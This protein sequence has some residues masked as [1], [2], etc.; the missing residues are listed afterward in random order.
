M[1]FIRYSTRECRMADATDIPLST[2]PLRSRRA[3]AISRLAAPLRDPFAAVG[4][5]I[6]TVFLVIALLADAIAPHDPLE[7]LFTADGNLA[8][9]EP[10]GWQHPLGTTNLGRD[11][12]SQLLVGTRA[13]LIVGLTAAVAVASIG[14]V[15][16]LISGF[17]GGWTDAVLMRFT[18]IA[19]GIPFLPFVILIS[20]L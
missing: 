2:A 20:G 1:F 16:G 4:F 13:A 11:I 9:S 19:L 10:P 7:I 12:F 8:R 18:D 5:L 15:V 17:F 6:Y 3:R 14:T